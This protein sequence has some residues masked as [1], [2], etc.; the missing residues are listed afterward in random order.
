M[1]V[2]GDSSPVRENRSSVSPS[3]GDKS[4][5]TRDQLCGAEEGGGGGTRPP[6]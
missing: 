1:A 2:G 4:W 3:L 5:C 6:A